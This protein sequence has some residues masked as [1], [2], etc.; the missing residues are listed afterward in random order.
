M[1]GRSDKVKLI[2]AI[3]VEKFSPK[4]H[5]I[6]EVITSDPNKPQ[7]MVR[8]EVVGSKFTYEELRA[9]EKQVSAEGKEDKLTKGS[10]LGKKK[11]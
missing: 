1:A 9:K 2:S 5:V 6:E 7:S 3:R 4:D 11:K 8:E 10:F